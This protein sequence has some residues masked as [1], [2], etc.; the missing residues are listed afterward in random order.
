[1]QEKNNRAFLSLDDMPLYGKCVFCRIDLN[2]P[3]DE[4]TGQPQLSLRIIAH[5][6]T[7]LELS[8]MGAKVVLLAHQGR[9]G[10]KDFT[11]LEFHAKLLEQQVQ[12]LALENSKKAP[13]ILFVDDVCGQKAKSAI[14]AMKEGDVILLENVRYL[15]DETEYEKNGGKSQL[16]LNLSQ[17]CEAFVLDA[18][19]CAHRAHASV[20]GFSSVPCLAGRVMEKEL[21]A[22]LKFKNPQKPVVFVLGGAKPGAFEEF[23]A[24]KGA[25][26][27]L[28]SAKSLLLKYPSQII[29]PSDLVVEEN[30]A[31]KTIST[32]QL[33]TS[34]MIMDIGPQTAL[35][36]CSIISSASSI[37]M[38]GPVGV[39]EK[40]EYSSGTR[41][42]LQAIAASKG[43]S[44]LGGGH[45]LSA[46]DKFSLSHSSFGYVS[47]SGKALIEYLSGQSLP[48]V[49]LLYGWAAKRAGEKGKAKRK[50][51]GKKKAKK[52]KKPYNKPKIAG[53]KAGKR[54]QK[55]RREKKNRKNAKRK[56]RKK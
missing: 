9:K 19:S 27:H 47:L 35:R 28:E 33:P 53:K 21:N 42:V 36:F 56:R 45:T 13:K 34:C 37:I 23:L 18:F 52:S 51:K 55:K 31:A 25:L 12:K 20:V 17:F 49:E 11:S 32:S 10:D 3:I 2:S 41:Q 30:G 54:Q 48:G 26:E 50:E 24:K 1:M 46:I 40:D 15:D 43:F 6:Q 38:N 5:A 4:K 39:Y 7:V 29:L 22:L 44:L 16:V 14:K 8:C